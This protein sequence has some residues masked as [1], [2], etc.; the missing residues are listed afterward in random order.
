MKLFEM[1]KRRALKDFSR[2][3]ARGRI[4]RR[5]QGTVTSVPVAQIVGSAGK[6]AS[7][8]GR[9]RY[10]S[11][12]VDARL[13]RLREANAFA[14]GVFPP[15]DLYQINDD[16]YV[17][18]GHHRVALA[19]ENDQVEIDAHV[20]IAYVVEYPAAPAETSAPASSPL[21]WLSWLP[22]RA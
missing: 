13:R 5:T 7:M 1:K 10:K 9:F 3:L 2:E 21:R 6:A 16:Y 17:I 8:D 14:R 22:G 11:G 20:H 19:L 12:K 18:D 15:V 4:V